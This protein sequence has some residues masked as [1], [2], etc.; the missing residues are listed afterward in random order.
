MEDDLPPAPMSPAFGLLNT[1]NC[2][3]RAGE[4]KR[5]AEK[6]HAGTGDTPHW[7]AICLGLLSPT[8][9]GCTSEA[10]KDMIGK[11]RMQLMKESAG[12]ILWHE[13]EAPKP[14][15]RGRQDTLILLRLE[16]R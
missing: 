13:T 9:G 10:V 6:A 11:G 5:A 7:A 14:E 16:K 3:L 2:G 12:K 8:A 4:S 15:N 1:G